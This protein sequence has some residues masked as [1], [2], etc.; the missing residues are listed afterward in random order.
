PLQRI[1]RAGKHLLQLINDI[2]DLSKIEAGKMELHHERFELG[3]MI[4]DAIDMAGSLASRNNNKIE[5]HHPE[6]P[7]VLIS[8]ITRLRQVVFNLLSNACKFTE[9][10]RVSVDVTEDKPGWIQIAVSDTGIGMTPEQMKRLF[11][12]F[13]QA[14]SSTTRKYGG[15]GLGLAI[16]MRFCQMMGGEVTVESK[17][18]EGSIFR[19]RLPLEAPAL[20]PNPLLS[21]MRPQKPDQ[22]PSKGRTILV[23]EDDPIAQDIMKR[24]LRGEGYQVVV[25]DDGAEGLR[26]AREIRPALITLDV[27]MPKVDGWGVLAELKSDPGLAH[28]PVIMVTIADD[29]PKGF[30]MGVTDYVTKPVDRKSLLRLLETYGTRGGSKNVLVVDDEAETR[31]RIRRVL[32]SEG[33]R[34]REAENGNAALQR[35]KEAAEKAKIELSS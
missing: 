16:S 31:K 29:R 18:G 6:H 33:W 28:I 25:A 11:S 21:L 8:D 20:K 32:A 22:K 10:G 1:N 15:T 4:D 14:D 24:L 17:P 12:D 13:S 23:I 34:V 27:I 19:V 3:A 30:A 5:V 26:L 2:L 35:L 7:V 9:N